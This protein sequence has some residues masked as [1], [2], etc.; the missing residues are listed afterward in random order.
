MD[1]QERVIISAPALTSK[2]GGAWP[3]GL[4]SPLKSGFEGS[5][6]PWSARIRPSAARL[7]AQ[8][9]RDHW[10]PSANRPWRAGQND[11]VRLVVVGSQVVFHRTLIVRVGASKTTCFLPHSGKMKRLKSCY[12]SFDLADSFSR[13]SF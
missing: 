3:V 2:K 10:L 11:Q 1:P 9:R 8:K 4:M 13:S 7:D 12:F 6:R 5:C